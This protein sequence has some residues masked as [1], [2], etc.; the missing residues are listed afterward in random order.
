[1]LR[2]DFVDGSNEDVICNKKCTGTQENF[3]LKKKKKTQIYMG[4]YTLWYFK[5]GCGVMKFNLPRSKQ[6]R[7][8]T[9]NITEALFMF[10]PCINDN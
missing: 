5:G 6:D 4:G 1:M 7:K 10:A 8:R 3:F 2:Y 9:H